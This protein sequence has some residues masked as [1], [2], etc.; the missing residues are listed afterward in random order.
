MHM[1][2]QDMHKLGELYLNKGK[3]KKK[4]LISSEWI[5]RTTS[6]ETLTY[7]YIGHYG[8]HWWVSETSESESY[9]FAMGL[10]G[11]YICVI[12]S[13]LTVVSLT[14]DTYGETLKPM[15]I[16]NRVFCSKLKQQGNLF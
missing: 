16:I 4:Q 11:Q 3:W 15:Q 8:R 5:A 10:G 6:S 13:R 2:V 9:Y 1:N 7:P 12:P 14:S